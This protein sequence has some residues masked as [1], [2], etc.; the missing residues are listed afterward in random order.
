MG[1]NAMIRVDPLFK[2]YIERETKA[3]AERIKK[4]EGL[5]EVRI[6]LISGTFYLANRLMNSKALIKYRIKKISLN[7]GEIEF[8]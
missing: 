4:E 6:P 1:N 2:F 3:L 7:V 5:K 8:L